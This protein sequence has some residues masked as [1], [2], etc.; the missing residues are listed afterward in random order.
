ML[1]RASA[2]E[3]WVPA[4]AGTTI[5]VIARARLKSGRALPH[6]GRGGLSRRNWGGMRFFRRSLPGTGSRP[7]VAAARR[8]SSALLGV[9]AILL[10]AAVFVWHQHALVFNSAGQPPGLSSQDRAA[11][12]SSTTADE[13]CELC[14]ALHHLSGAPGEFVAVSPPSLAASRFAPI[15]KARSGLVRTLAFNARAPPHV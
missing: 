1:A 7:Q 11:P 6:D 13:T 4:F 10:Q 2:A 3:K 5:L 12:L 14:A 9:Y 8:R 15:E